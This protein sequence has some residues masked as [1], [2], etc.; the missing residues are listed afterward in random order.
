[1]VIF[2][3]KFGSMYLNKLAKKSYDLTCLRMN[4]DEDFSLALSMSI[5]KQYWPQNNAIF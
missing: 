5:L 1:M 2:T 4:M 3:L